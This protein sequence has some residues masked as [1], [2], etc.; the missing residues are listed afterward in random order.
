MELLDPESPDF[1]VEVVSVVEAVQE[2]PRPV[3]YAQERAARGDA[4]G[5]MKAEGVEYEERMEL[6]DQIT[7]PRPLEEM[8]EGA[9]STYRQTNPWVA[10]YELKP[11]TVVREMVEQ[12]MTF[13][14]LIS[15]YQLARA[16]GVVLRYLTDTY[17]AMR[18]LVPD[19]LRT[20]EVEAIITWLGD[21]V[22]AV[23]SSLLD[24]WEQLAAGRIPGDPAT[25]DDTPSAE[26][27]FG[28]DEHG[29]LPLT[30]NRHAFRVLVRNALF[31][32]VDALAR[33]SF[34]T[35]ER[36][37]AGHARPAKAPDAGA[38][39]GEPGL[40][41]SVS[42]DLSPSG[43]RS[44]GSPWAAQRWEQS[45]AP[46]WREYEWLGADGA[47]RSAALVEFI[48]VPEPADL[49]SAVQLA[50]S[51]AGLATELLEQREAG[52]VWLVRQ[53]FADPRATMT[54]GSRP[55]SIST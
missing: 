17:R 40:G 28:E 47:A 29:R 24:E 5:A 54:G 36:L 4:I 6:A 35:L 21:L 12:A 50:E 44:A 45:M 42:A 19:R 43:A 39:A 3:L 14:D 30:R 34:D 10:D 32:Y 27:R 41:G 2:D 15:R 55:W 20:E 52:R 13:S 16:E 11:K 1:A 33:E 46:Y 8:L 22:R 18:Q 51:D 37:A 26:R 38:D 25:E 7:W 31:R 23:D 48:E 53:T 9:L 49:P